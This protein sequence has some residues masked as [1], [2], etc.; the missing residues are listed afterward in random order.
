MSPG[1]YS[2]T[3]LPNDTAA[4]CRDLAPPFGSFEV[5]VFSGPS[6]LMLTAASKRLPREVTAEWFWGN[7]GQKLLRKVTLRPSGGVM[8]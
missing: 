8:I 4:R 6:R 2:K 7:C 3:C 5:D 1:I